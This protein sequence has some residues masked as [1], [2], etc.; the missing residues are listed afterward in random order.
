MSEVARP[1]LHLITYQS[2]ELL[3]LVLYP[4]NQVIQLCVFV[5]L[6]TCHLICVVC[7]V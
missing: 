4:R 6:Y 5:S 3:D 7:I 2:N 1:A